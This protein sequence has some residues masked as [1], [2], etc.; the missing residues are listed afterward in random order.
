MQGLLPQLHGTAL[1]CTA[2]HGTALHRAAL[3]DAD[4]Y[5]DREEA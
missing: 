1:H 2:L 4:G 5:I 3:G